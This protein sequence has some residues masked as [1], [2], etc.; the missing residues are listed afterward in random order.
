MED[1]Q[2]RLT[3]A[4]PGATNSI[5]SIHRRRWFLSMDR[6][7]SGFSACIEKDGTKTWRKVNDDQGGAV[8]KD[9]GFL[10][11]GRDHERSIVT[12]RTASE[13]MHDEG[14]QGYVGRKGWR[15]VVE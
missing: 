1:E 13:V 12:G 9:E 3:N 5:G 2:V 15:A 8:S 6:Q 7:A 10:V 11:L 14:V 4:Y